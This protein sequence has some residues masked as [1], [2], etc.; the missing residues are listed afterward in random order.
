ML[1]LAAKPFEETSTFFTRRQAN[2]FLGFL[3]VNGLIY[4]RLSQHHALVKGPGVS[5]IPKNNLLE[6]GKLANDI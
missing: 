1:I 5:G 4:P 3:A 6:A 2:R